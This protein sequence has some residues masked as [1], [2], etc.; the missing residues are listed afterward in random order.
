MDTGGNH[1]DLTPEYA[2]ITEDMKAVSQSLG[3]PFLRRTTMDDIM[4]NMIELRSKHGDR[5]VLRALHFLRENR[6]VEKLI[7][8]LGQGD[9]D[10]FKHL[11]VE[12]GH[13]SFE[14]LQNVYAM[15]NTGEPGVSL[16]LCIAECILDGKAR[17]AFTGEGFAG[18]TLN[19]VPDCLLSE[20]KD[21]MESVF[22]EK[23]LPCAYGPGGR[24]ALS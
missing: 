6:R 19:F 21:K 8:A 2:A 13:S 24:E 3:V 17:G 11:I 18:T 22:R 16:S 23:Q 15:C 1:A 7:E 4:R 14:Y 20:F 10:E 12:K 9:F 5:A